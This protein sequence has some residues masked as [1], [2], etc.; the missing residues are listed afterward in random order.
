[1][2]DGNEWPNALNIVGAMSRSEPP[3]RKRTFSS[4]LTRMNGTGFVV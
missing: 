2:S 3:I 4:S 1:M